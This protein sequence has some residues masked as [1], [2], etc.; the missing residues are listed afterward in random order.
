MRW[1]KKKVWGLHTE[2]GALRASGTRLAP[3]E[4]ECRRKTK[5]R[6]GILR[7]RWGEVEKEKGPGDLFP[8]EPT[9]EARQ[10]EETLNLG[11]KGLLGLL[12]KN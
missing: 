9:D 3:I 12:T 7:G 10:G 11:F 8:T 5:T 1:K 6:R 2:D 4:T